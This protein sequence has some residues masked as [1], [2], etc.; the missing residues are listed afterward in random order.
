M[1]ADFT[2]TIVS[3]KTSVWEHGFSLTQGKK[4][5]GAHRRNNFHSEGK[6]QYKSVEGKI[7]RTSPCPG[8]RIQPKFL[9]SLRI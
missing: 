7:Y 5:K 4:Y 3:Q 2:Q 9:K 8:G 1:F 6:F